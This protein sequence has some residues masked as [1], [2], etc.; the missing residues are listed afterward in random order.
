MLTQVRK[1]YQSY[2]RRRCHQ[3]ASVNIDVG[4]LKFNSPVGL[5]SFLHGEYL[6]LNAT[7]KYWV[8]ENGLKIAQDARDSMKWSIC[9]LY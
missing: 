5:Y 6:T 2:K 9:R 8:R 4:I 3:R 1:S 7:N